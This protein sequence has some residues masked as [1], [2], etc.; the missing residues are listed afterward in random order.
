MSSHQE[1]SPP[2]G[3]LV[4]NQANFVPLSPITFLDHTASLYPRHTALIYGELRRSWAEVH[5]RSRRL[6]S[7]LRQAGIGRGDRVAVLGANTPEVFEAHFGVPMAGAVLNMINV[8]LDSS[9]VAQI[10]HHGGA[11]LLIADREFSR[12]VAPALQLLGR[13]IQVIDIDD[14]SVEGGELLGGMDYEAFIATG[15]PAFTWTGPADEWDDIALSYTSGTTDSCKGVVYSHRGAYISSVSNVLSC[16]LPAKT[17]FLWALPMF[18]C[19]GWCFP[20]SLA[21]V[22]GTSVCIRQVRMEGMIETID[23]EQVTHLC[24]APFVLN[25]L[26]D[27]PTALQQKLRRGVNFIVG[28]AAPT[29]TLLKEAEQVGLRVTHGYGL[30]ETYGAAVLCAWHDEWN[31][32][33]PE[34]R[35]RLRARQGTGS[36]ATDMLMVADSDSLQP[37]PR[38]GESLG[39]VFIRG[40]NVMKGYLDNPEA[41]AEAFQ[42]GWFHTG[43]LA[44]WHPDGYIEVKDRRKDMIIPAAKKFRA[45]KWKPSSNCIRR[46]SMWRSSPSPIRNG[47]KRRAPLSPCVRTQ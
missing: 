4:K 35:A 2:Q 28:G 38:D 32:L 23:R 1:A 16:G 40:N 13:P 25:M 31:P 3:G 18:H 15:D 44:V 19:N 21:V 11:K 43:D 36:L 39:E 20:W 45:E 26:I 24:G 47:V 41:T 34:E 22:A 29:A 9:T 7:A 14:D 8:R 12:L 6:A 33:P 46:C 42:G 30:T 37:V 5:E 17:V 27:A 10:L